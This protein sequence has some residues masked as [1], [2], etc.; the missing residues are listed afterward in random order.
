MINPRPWGRISACLALACALPAW[1][2]TPGGLD[3][4][5]ANGAIVATCAVSA[6]GVTY[7][8]H[9]EFGADSA[10]APHVLLT[11][12]AG[13]PI[14][15]LNGTISV[16]GGNSAAVK[17]DGSGVV[18]PV[19]IA[20]L[21]LPANAAQETG[22][23]LAAIAANTAGAASAANQTAVQ[24]S[25]GASAAKAL[26]VQGV[27]G[28]RPVAVDGSS[29][30]QPVSAASLPL[31]AGAATAANQPTL[32]ADGGALAHVTDFPAT[33]AVSAAALP[34]PANAAQE[35]GGNL[36]TIA[37][38]TAGLATA[39]NQAAALAS[40]GSSASRALGVQGVAG[41][42]AM[43]VDGSSVTQPV[44]VASL[45]LPAGAATAA[46]Q[47][48]LNTDG[49]ALAHITNLPA[50]Q[51]V[52]WSAQSVTAN[53]GTNLNT[54]ALALESG[55]NLAAARADLD[56]LS[57]SAAT[58]ATAANQTSVQA[59]AGAGAAKALA[60]QGIGGGVAIKTDGSAVTQ[61]VSAASLPLPAGA[62]TA[63]NQT[64]VLGAVAPGAAPTNG[65]PALAQYNATAP[66]PASGQTLALQTNAAGALKTDP[67]GVTAPMNLVQVGG[68]GVATGPGAAGAATARVAVAQDA[69]TI[70]GT[71][72]TAGITVEPGN[73]PNTTPWLTQA[74]YSHFVVVTK[75]FT[76]SSS[77]PSGWYSF[78]GLL[79]IDLHN[80]VG[81]QVAN[82]VLVRMAT[83]STGAAVPPANL[84]LAFWSGLPQTTYTDDATFTYNTSDNSLF[85]G[86]LTLANNAV[87]D[88][89]ASSDTVLVG[90]SSP[91]SAWGPYLLT[92][93]SAGKL[94][95]TVETQGG[96]SYTSPTGFTVLF[97][98]GY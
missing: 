16:Q 47:P 53:A 75:T 18:Q 91:S 57:T 39:A 93:D 24:A 83:I 54:S 48:T 73:T 60:V 77:Y 6:G 63:A 38:N 15:N 62:A 43:K 42:L 36:A 10:G 30:T 64:A 13:R 65:V 81:A 55:G 45:P 68:T 61:P 59:A 50:T 11:D 85:L 58:S 33:Q 44:S 76:P 35:T 3:V 40:P 23:N 4:R 22:G 52:T 8:C 98:F 56:T 88:Q 87:W 89:V 19:S 7:P 72:P 5:D 27:A 90:S 29:V 2:Q 20:A 66:T 9:L 41:G 74:Q 86:E 69:S 80:Y 14:V 31:P 82:V 49:G 95:A 1:G 51:A 21:P 94:Y 97:E 34:L 67:S 17:T 37:A 78:G 28:G 46:G 71:S 96:E 92:T 70:A 12:T 26:G 25:A 79:S 84:N 32:N